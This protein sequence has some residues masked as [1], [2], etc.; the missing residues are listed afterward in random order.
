[1]NRSV[2][3]LFIPLV[4]TGL[5]MAACGGNPSAVNIEA[6]VN[7]QVQAAL[8]LSSGTPTAIPPTPIPPTPIPSTPVPSTPIPSTPMPSTPIPPTPTPSP[9]WD[10]TNWG[11]DGYASLVG[12]VNGDGKADRVVYRATDGDWGCWITDG[13]KCSWDATK[14]G[15]ASYVPLLGDVNGDGRADRVAYRPTDGNWGNRIN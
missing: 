13:D 1:M 11:G 5:A 4:A 10:G 7:A 3:V 8:A 6:T 9:S 14:W 12:D 2:F 15:D